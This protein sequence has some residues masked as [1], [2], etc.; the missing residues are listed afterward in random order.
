MRTRLQILFLIVFSLTLHAQKIAKVNSTTSVDWRKSQKININ[1]ISTWIHWDGRSDINYNN[2]GFEFPKGSKKYCFYQSGIIWGGKVND[3]IRVGGSTYF[4]SL[5]QGWI[6]PNGQPIDINDQR[7][8]IYKVRKNFET[9]DLTEEAT[10]EERTV[11]EIYKQ[12]KKGAEEWPVDLGAPFDDVNGDE[13]YTFGIDNPGITGAHQTIWYVANDIKFNSKPTFIEL[14]NTVWAYNS[15]YPLDRTIFKKYVL[16]NQGNEIIHDMYI[17]MFSDPDIGTANE[18]AGCDTVFN[19]GYS[20]KSNL[21][22][23]VYGTKPPA[24]GFLLLQGPMVN[25]RELQMTSFHYNKLPFP[26]VDPD[27]DMLR[28]IWVYNALQGLIEYTGEKFIDPITGEETKFPLS[29]DPVNKIGWIDSQLGITDKRF[30]LSSGPFDFEPGDTQVVIFAQIAAQGTDRLESV[31]Q[32]KRLAFQLIYSFPSLMGTYPTELPR[33]VPEYFYLSQNYP[34]PFN[35]STEIKYEIP[36]DCSVTLRV[37][38][39]LGREVATLVDEYK[40]AGIYNSTFNINNLTLSSGVY[41]YS[42]QAGPYYKYKKM[43]FIK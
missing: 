12:Y 24:V 23:T 8:R 2:A 7:V 15:A 9:D 41:I 6:Q 37:Y 20:Y 26:D 11:D 43:M 5:S 27:L 13:I 17:G 25:G 38:D 1:N 30:Y 34:N 29:G 19:L 21:L 16:I 32:L 35:P 14:Q 33:E 22:D 40:Q 42:L 36:I 28:N 18:F 31:R 10:D 3:E 39:L 4:S